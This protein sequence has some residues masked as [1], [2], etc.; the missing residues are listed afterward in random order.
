MPA[1]TFDWQAIQQRAS[2]L[3]V[4]LTEYDQALL[5]DAMA[6]MN[7]RFRW[8]VDDATYDAIEAAVS[9]AQEAIMTNVLIGTITFRVGQPPANELVCDGQQYARADYPDLYDALVPIFH[10]DADNFV[11][12]NLIDKFIKGA[13]SINGIGTSGGSNT[14]TLTEAEMP[15]HAHIYTP[16]ALNVDLE[17]AGVPDVFAASVGVPTLTSSVGGGQ[18]HNNQPYHMQVIPCLIAK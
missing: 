18:P 11:T 3:T 8:P 15:S 7:D 12:P 16:P 9:K 10:V 17:A 13:T 1:Q 14:H 5:L 4:F 2:G 6:L